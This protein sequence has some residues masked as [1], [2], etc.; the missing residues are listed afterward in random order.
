MAIESLVETS[1]LDLVTQALKDC[2]YL[3]VGMNPLA[4][5]VN[6]AFARLQWMLSSW[7]R[8]RYLVYHLVTYVLPSTGQITPYSI[9]PTSAALTP[10]ISVG[11]YGQSARP[12]RLES[13]VFRQLFTP[14][15]QPIDWPLAPLGSM[16]DYNE[17]VRIKNL[18]NF[19]LW[20]FYDPAWPIGQIYLW[21]WPSANVYAIVMTARE[22]LPIGF[23]LRDT[24][25]IPFEY[26]QAMVSNLALLLR[27]KYGIRGGPGDELPNIARDSKMVLRA[28]NTA[29]GT[30]SMPATIVRRGQ[31]DIFSDTNF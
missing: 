4:E 22:Q 28:G 29:L 16:E 30:L 2:G 23:A 3:G 14:S 13:G 7:E 21:P 19:G 15:S 8:Q 9:G 24:V 11:A 6:E 17:K 18:T 5:D 25:N 1:W 20:Y 12:N 10:Q 31:Y 26:Y 27:P